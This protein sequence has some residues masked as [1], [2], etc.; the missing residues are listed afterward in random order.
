MLDNH[1]TS[2]VVFG[3]SSRT[4]MQEAMTS[5]MMLAILVL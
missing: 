2:C 1:S 4:I 3:I 5:S